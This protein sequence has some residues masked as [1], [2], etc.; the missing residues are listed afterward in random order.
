MSASFPHKCSIV[1]MKWEQ[2][3]GFGLALRLIVDRENVDCW[4]QLASQKEVSRG[5]GVKK[6]V[7]G[8]P[9]KYCNET[10]K[11]ERKQK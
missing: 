5:Q 1:K 4:V 7:K 10:G 11:S 6:V 9:C 2:G 8:D 3:D